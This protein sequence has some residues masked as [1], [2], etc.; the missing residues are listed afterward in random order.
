M[1]SSGDNKADYIWISEKGE[2]QVY[3]NVI[4][5][6]SAKFVPYND[7]KFVATGVGGS[8]DEIRL[9]DIK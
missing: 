8:R 4:G 2:M 6:N 1:T 9:A 3:L 7:G 5:E